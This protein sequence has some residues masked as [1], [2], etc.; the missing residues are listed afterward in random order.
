MT[1]PFGSPM[2]HQGLWTSVEALQSEVQ[3][4]TAALLCVDKI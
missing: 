2:D 1:A 3:T 4:S